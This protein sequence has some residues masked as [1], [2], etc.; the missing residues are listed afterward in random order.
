MWRRPRFRSIL[1]AA[2][3]TAL[4]G[5]LTAILC[6]PLS[7]EPSRRAFNLGADTR[8]FLWTLAWDAHALRESPLALFDANIFYPEP[9]TLAFSEHLL[10]TAVLAAPLLWATDDPLLAMNFVLLLSTTLTGLGA[11]FLARCLGAGFWGSLAAGIIFAFAPP[12]LFRLGQL[13]LATTQWM[14]FCLA[15]VHLYAAGGTRRHLLAAGLFFTLQALSGGYNGL[16]LLLA[17]GGLVLY[18]MLLGGFRPSS[19]WLRDMVVVGALLAALNGPFLLPYLEARRDV[20]LE[21]SLQEA[22]E[23]SPNAASFLATPAHM[24]RWL[25]SPFPKLREEV[26]KNARSYLFPGFLTLGLALFGIGRRKETAPIPYEGET[27]SPSSPML[28]IWDTAILAS[29]LAALLI[30]AAGGIRWEVFSL[31]LS[32]RSGIRAGWVFVVLALPRLALARRHPFSLK[33]YFQRAIFWLKCQAET[34]VGLS[35]GFYVLLVVFSLWASLGPDFGLYS[36]LY[37][38]LPGFDFIRGPGRLA[39]LTLLGLA[40]LAGFGLERLLAGRRARTRRFLGVTVVTLLV[41]ELA[42]VPLPAEPYEI[43]I[44]AIDRWLAGQPALPLVELPI[45]DP[46]DALRASRL[47]SVYMLHA[48]AH[49]MKMVNGYS[50][51]TPHRHDALF[52]KLVN[53]PDEASLDALDD[54]GVRYVIIHVELYLPG[55]W[56][57]VNQK[58]ESFSERLKLL[59]TERQDGEGRAYLLNPI[60]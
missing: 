36:A 13:H 53:F 22:Q 6:F 49:W 52:R 25:L 50:G 60:Q 18:L 41:A 40:V 44:P 2:A 28:L 46:R 10:G 5:A 20:G 17:A 56:D 42:A 38:L 29:L 1:R 15:F 14:P 55:E 8:L 19:R 57:R 26:M 34:R 51:L 33:G 31:S 54:I 47:H 59:R 21:R 32:A 48:M 7:L 39:I 3:L 37:R 35:A 4:L 27:A 12:R 45:A 23:F 16:F 43:R 11:Y 9:N 30:E 24:Q 58:I